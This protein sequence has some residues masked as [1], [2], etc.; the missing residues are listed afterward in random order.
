MRRTSGLTLKHEKPIKDVESVVSKGQ[1]Q[2]KIIRG[3]L[4][5]L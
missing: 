4:S 3:L 5:E 1:I 2:G